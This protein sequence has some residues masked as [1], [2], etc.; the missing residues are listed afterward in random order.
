M[1]IEIPVIKE[2]TIPKISADDAIL[3][4]I[5]SITKSNAGT[6]RREM[7]WFPKFSKGL[8]DSGR[9]VK[10]DFFDAYLSYRGTGDWKKEMAK[11]NQFKSKGK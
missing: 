2:V 11:I 10:I 6:I 1:T 9:I 8:Q 4:E 7:K 3:S 5:F